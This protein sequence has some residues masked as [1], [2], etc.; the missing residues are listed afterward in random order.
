MSDQSKALGVDLYLSYSHKDLCIVLEHDSPNLFHIFTLEWKWI[1]FLNDL[2]PSV[3][4]KKLAVTSSHCRQPH[5]ITDYISGS[6][7]NEHDRE[8]KKKTKAV[9]NR[10]QKDHITRSSVQGF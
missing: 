10:R 7:K 3:D 1:I 9:L 2:F 5:F 6:Q 8:K 4:L